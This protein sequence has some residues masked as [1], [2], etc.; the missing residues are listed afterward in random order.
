MKFT[1][2]LE[3]KEQCNTSLN[4]T[5]V[6]LWKITFT[7]KLQD[8]TLVKAMDVDDLKSSVKALYIWMMSD[9]AI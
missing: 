2:Y 5:K 7:E 8:D 4:L 1:D 6:R 9:E 3:P